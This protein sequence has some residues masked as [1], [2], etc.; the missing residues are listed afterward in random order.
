MQLYVCDES[1]HLPLLVKNSAA[2]QLFG[3]I[4]A[5]RVYSS[6]REQNNNQNFDVECV[7]KEG[8]QNTSAISCPKVDLKG[9]FVNNCSLE[10]ACKGHK[11]RSLQCNK[12]MNFF[13]IWFILLKMLLLQGK[14]SP[15]KFEIAVNASLD[16]E[17]GRFEMVSVSIPCFNN[18]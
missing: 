13:L 7:G 3:N 8:H 18:I 15:L 10:D 1:E 11:S 4:N 16:A 2:E 5:E 9:F 12:N 6:C 14:N 17:N